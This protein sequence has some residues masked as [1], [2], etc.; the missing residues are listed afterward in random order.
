MPP[1]MGAYC[2]RSQVILSVDRSRQRGND[3]LKQ[4][5]VH[6]SIFRE[7]FPGCRAPVHKRIVC[8]RFATAKTRNSGSSGVLNRICCRYPRSYDFKRLIHR[9][10][11]KVDAIHHSL[12]APMYAA[13]CSNIYLCRCIHSSKAKLRGPCG[14]GPAEALTRAP[15]GEHCSAAFSLLRPGEE[16]TRLR[17][18]AAS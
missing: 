16:A 7:F 15:K 6:G 17:R 14:F 12:T 11:C 2:G 4:V 13:S 9:Y 1:W 8:K 18:R 10:F 5:I 3:V